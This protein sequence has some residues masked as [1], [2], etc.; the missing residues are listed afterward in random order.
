[1]EYVIIATSQHQEI[2]ETISSELRIAVL[3]GYVKT[4]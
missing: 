2:A 1:M 4:Q 3:K